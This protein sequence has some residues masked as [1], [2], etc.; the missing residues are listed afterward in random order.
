MAEGFVGDWKMTRVKK[1]N[2]FETFSQIGTNGLTNG[3]VATT[4]VPLPLKMG[5]GSHPDLIRV[6]G[7]NEFV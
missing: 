5:A 7:K 1:A 3:E 6:R 4:M 2:Q